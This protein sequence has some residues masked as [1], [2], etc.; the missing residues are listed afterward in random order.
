M[1]EENV[2]A[3]YGHIWKPYRKDKQTTDEGTKLILYFMCKVCGI[4][5]N[6]VGEEMEVEEKDYEP[7]E[8]FDRIIRTDE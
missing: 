4:T 5:F 7:K 2:C 1:V 3:L 6:T 8:T